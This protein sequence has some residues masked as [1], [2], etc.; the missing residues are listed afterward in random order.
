MKDKL[1]KT[2][3]NKRYYQIRFAFKTFLI[4][5]AVFALAAIPVGVSYSLTA[6]AKA[7]ENVS[8]ISSSEESEEEVPEMDYFIKK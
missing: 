7:A 8:Q 5:L 6:S 4:S 2:G 3:K 1:E